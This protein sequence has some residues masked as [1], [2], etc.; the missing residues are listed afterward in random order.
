MLLLM[1]LSPHVYLPPGSTPTPIL[2]AQQE[3]RLWNDFCPANCQQLPMQPPETHRHNYKLVILARFRHLL[4][5]VSSVSHFFDIQYL[6]ITELSSNATTCKLDESSI[7][8]MWV[9]S[10]IAENSLLEVFFVL[11]FFS[12]LSTVCK[13]HALNVVSQITDILNIRAFSYSHVYT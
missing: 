6:C 11:R 4:A 12:C 3:P 5:A 8:Q 9:L 1:L 2:A 13:K 10:H 7:D